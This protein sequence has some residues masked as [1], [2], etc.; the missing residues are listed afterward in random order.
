MYK[1][2]LNCDMG[3]AFAGYQLG[4]DAEIMPLISSANI[5]CGW[6]AGDP[7]VM[8]RTVELALQ[9]G[10]GIGAH[11]G[12]PDLL[13]FGRRN[14]GLTPEELRDY[15]IYQL[16]ALLGFV[17]ALGGRLQHVKAHGAMYNQAAADQRLAR[18]FCEAVAS[19]DQSL[20]LVGLAGSHLISEAERIGLSTASEVFA[21]R[22]YLPNGSLVPRNQPGA[23]LHDSQQVVDRV[24]E[25][26]TKSHVK[27]NDGTVISLQAD[28]ICVHGDTPEAL[29]HLKTLRAGLQQRGIQVANWSGR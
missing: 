11:P 18:A 13:G 29:Q 5:A 17:R 22:G 16:G 15:V 25:M 1:V 23:V 4:P 26:V 12:Y 9:H 8:R 6:H 27:T 28:T 2:D 21:D 10:V 7:R 19:F 24:V 20:V 3:E 14:L